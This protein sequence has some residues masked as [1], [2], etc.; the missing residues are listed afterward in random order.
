[1]GG[2]RTGIPLADM[3]ELSQECGGQLDGLGV[4]TSDHNIY[5]DPELRFPFGSHFIV[6]ESAPRKSPGVLV[7]KIT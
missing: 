3:P 1:M 6:S 5:P 4:G 7:V 2:D